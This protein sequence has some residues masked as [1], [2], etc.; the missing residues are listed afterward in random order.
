MNMETVNINGLYQFGID[1]CAPDSLSRQLVL[2]RNGFSDG[3]HRGPPNIRMPSGHELSCL[4]KEGSLHREATGGVGTP[5]YHIHELAP[6]AQPP[7]A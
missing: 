7:T 3:L 1:T 6:P 4:D 5:H 2:A